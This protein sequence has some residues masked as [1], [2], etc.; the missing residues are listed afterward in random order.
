MTMRAPAGCLWLVVACEWQRELLAIGNLQ[1]AGF[2]TFWCHYR[3]E[4]AAHP[5]NGRKAIPVLRGYYPPWLFV[6]VND[7]PSDDVAAIK[8]ARYVDGVLW[9][10][11]DRHYLPAAWLSWVTGPKCHAHAADLPVC[12][13][14]VTGLFEPPT[15]ARTL[16]RQKYQPG[17]K[18]RTVGLWDQFVSTVIADMG[19]SIEVEH[20]QMF[21][22]PVRRVYDPVQVERA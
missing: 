16:G 20:G 14:P 3:T 19:K 15:G 7:D 22:K 12:I 1:E 5:R 8:A 17:A 6:A 10:E 2:T 21:G 11:A 13:D 18:V 4:I 9:T